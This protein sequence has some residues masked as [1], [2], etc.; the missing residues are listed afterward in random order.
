MGSDIYL[1][2]NTP[3]FT[4]NLCRNHE[5]QTRK[6]LF[7]FSVFT[8]YSILIVKILPLHAFVTLTNEC[9]VKQQLF[10]DSS[11]HVIVHCRLWKFATHVFS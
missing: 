7:S 8:P 5:I 11:L 10:A 6:I 9:T 3:L 1:T 4:F 2:Q